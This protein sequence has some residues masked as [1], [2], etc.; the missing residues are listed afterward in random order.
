[1]ASRSDI[2][3][4]PMLHSPDYPHTFPTA[5]GTGETSSALFTA[6]YLVVFVPPRTRGFHL[7]LERRR[8]RPPSPV[9]FGKSDNLHMRR[10]H[11]RPIAAKM[12][13]RETIG[14]FA[15]QNRVGQPMGHAVFLSL[16]DALHVAISKRRDSALPV[17]APCQIVNIDTGCK[18]VLCLRFSLFLIEFRHISRLSDHNNPHHQFASSRTSRPAS[19]LASWVCYESGKPA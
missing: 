19:G 13:D 2:G 5:Q 6:I 1:M 14:N 3:R 16:V 7:R 12:I 17:P 15:Y 8:S 11:A 18:E 9:I 4:S 10:I